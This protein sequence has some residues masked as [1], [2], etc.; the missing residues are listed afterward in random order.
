MR[1]G[2]S[3]SSTNGVN[4]IQAY[5]WLPRPGAKPRGLLYIAHG[6]AEY[7]LRYDA[8]ALQLNEAGYIVL[9]DDHLGHGGSVASDADL[10]YW[11][12]GD[13]SRHVIDDIH[14]LRLRYQAEYPDLPFHMLGH[15]MGSM[16]LR[17]YLAVY[18]EGLASA[19]IVGAPY[20]TNGTAWAATALGHTV[21]LFRGE[22][23]RSRFIDRLSIKEPLARIP[24]A[25]TSFAWLSKDQENVRSYEADPHCGFLFTV[26]GQLNL[27][28]LARHMNELYTSASQCPKDLPM[29]LL[30]GEDDPVAEYGKSTAK[31]E[32]R[33]RASGYTDVRRIGYPTLRHEILNEVE[34]PKIVET[35]ISFLD[36]NNGLI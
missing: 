7:A 4:Q 12:P 14:Q 20:I 13:A 11:G 24:D 3:Y 31:I 35:I 22:R 27:F 8:M 2:I 25:K 21:R 33:L 1:C 6:M 28:R 34:A 16:L 9:A 36:A 19:T 5:C 10:G 17:Y 32:E 23:H 30:V 15:S 26:N 18:G 29:L